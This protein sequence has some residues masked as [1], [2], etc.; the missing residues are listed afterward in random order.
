MALDRDRLL[1]LSDE[2]LFKACRF[3][4]FRATGPGGQHRNKTDSAARLTLRDHP[5]IAASAVG[6]RSQ[7]RNRREALK[8]LRFEIALNM[9]RPEPAPWTGEWTISRRNA[10]YPLMAA[11]IL[12]ALEKHD[13]Q[14][15]DAA[16]DLGLST[17]K[18]IKILSHGPKLWAK[19]NRERQSRDLHPLRQ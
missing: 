9:R 11:T 13:Y 16:K 10:L 6:S 7:H 8:Q 2:A 19:V 18:L 5:D 3:E 17:G 15:S 4:T 12:D 14:V 1:R